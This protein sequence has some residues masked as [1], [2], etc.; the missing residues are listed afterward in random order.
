[1]PIN[2]S[3]ISELLYIL[4]LLLYCRYLL[5]NGADK[6]IVT[7]DAERPIDLVD[8]QD[9]Q[10]IAIMLSDDVKN[11]NHESDSLR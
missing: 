10:T 3:Q 1:M 11:S 6:N 9:F 2:L 8:A 4:L 5:Q 7:D